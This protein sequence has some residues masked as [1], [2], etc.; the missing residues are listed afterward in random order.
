M[1]HLFTITALLL[2]PLAALAEKQ[3]SSRVPEEIARTR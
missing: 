2:V 3:S 1:K